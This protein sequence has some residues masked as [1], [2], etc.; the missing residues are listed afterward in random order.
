M[1]THKE[2]MLFSREQFVFLERLPLLKGE[3]KKKEKNRVFLS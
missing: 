2:K 1:G 3:A